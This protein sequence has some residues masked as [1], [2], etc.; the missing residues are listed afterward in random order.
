MV[1]QMVDTLSDESITDRILICEQCE[2]F[3]IGNS[4][5][6]CP[7]LVILV[8]IPKWPSNLAIAHN[9]LFSTSGN[10]TL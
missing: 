2:N 4:R 6:L 7:Q 1:F 10:M 9:E 8:Y 3:G 5:V